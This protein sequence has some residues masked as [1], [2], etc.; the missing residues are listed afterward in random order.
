MAAPSKW[1][2]PLPANKTDQ[3]LTKSE[4][5]ALDMPK[6][7]E[8]MSPKSPGR[9]NADL[10]S[11]TPRKDTSQLDYAQRAIR[12]LTP[13]QALNAA[14][15]KSLAPPS[16]HPGMLGSAGAPHSFSKDSETM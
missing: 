4:V 8:G 14:V 9:D 12:Q 10:A 13:K 5:M 7:E 6:E 16:S 11:A 1:T 2:L 3:V 15:L